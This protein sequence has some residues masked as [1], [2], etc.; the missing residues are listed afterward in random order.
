[1]LSSL[2][3]RGRLSLGL[4]SAVRRWVVLALLLA[5]LLWMEMAGGRAGPQFPFLNKLG[6]S[7]Q[8]SIQRSGAAAISPAGRGGEGKRWGGA[9]GA[10]SGF[11]DGELLWECTNHS[12]QCAKMVPLRFVLWRSEP[13]TGV[14]VASPSSSIMFDKFCRFGGQ[15]IRMN[16]YLIPRHGGETDGEIY[17]LAG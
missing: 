4:P 9:H 13:A 2:L 15:G 5:A 16:F 8:I 11:G 7:G 10:R 1:M 6:S 14:G 17:P 3:L 12:W